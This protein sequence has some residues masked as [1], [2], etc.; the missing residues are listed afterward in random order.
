MA[1]DRIDQFENLPSDWVAVAAVGLVAYIRFGNRKNPVRELL[2]RLDAGSDDLDCD[3]WCTNR[4]LREAYEAGL[5][6][7]RA[8]LQ[9]RIDSA[10]DMAGSR[11]SEWGDRAVAVA[12]ILEGDK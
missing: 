8:E 1:D 5:R 9:E 2:D 7:G 12:E 11:W 3:L 4:A 10:L 6:E